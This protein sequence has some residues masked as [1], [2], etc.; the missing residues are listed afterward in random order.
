MKRPSDIPAAHTNGSP[1]GPELPYPVDR[2]DG[3]PIPQRDIAQVIW[4]HRWAMLLTF[5]LCV[6]GAVLYLVKA[7]PIYT[8]SSCLFV[9]QSGP[10]IIATSEGFMTQSKNYLFTQAELLKSTPIVSGALDNLDSRRLRT[11]DGTIDRVGFLKRRLNVSVGKK[12]DLI[13][14][15]LDSQYPQE[16]AE[17]VNAVV[18]S[19][20]AYHSRQKKDT[21]AEVLNILQREKA[22]RDAELRQRFEAAMNFKRANETISFGADNNNIV[23]QRLM[24]LSDALTS[25][26]LAM[27]DARAQYEATREM[28]S[29]PETI[30]YVAETQHL[31]SGPG[32]PYRGQEVLNGEIDKLRVEIASLRQEC[33]ENHPAVQAAEAKLMCLKEQRDKELERSARAYVA[34]LERKYIASKGSVAELRRSLDEQRKLAQQWNSQSIQYAILEG[35]LKRTERLCDLLDSRI[36]EIDIGED[37]G[38]LNISI[39]ETAQ[40]ARRPS[41]PNKA[42][43]MALSVGL[44]MLLGV[45]LALLRNWM[46]HRLRSVEEISRALGLPVLGIVPHVAGR[47][48]PAS[49]GKVVQFE[50]NSQVAESYR[51]IRTG[52]YFGAPEGETKTILITSP[53]QRDGKSTLASNLG[54]A[55]AQAGQRVLILDADCR[56]PSQ[57]ETF[58]IKDKALGLSGLLTGACSLDQAIRH[59]DVKG[60]DVLPCGAVPP[61]P[62]EML[63]SRAFSKLLDG[64]SLRYDYILLDAPPIMPVA[65]ARILGAISD[66]ALLVLR[67][68]K[69]SRKPSQEAVEAL[70]K[71][72][73]QILGVVV[74]DVPISKG[75]YGYYR[76]GYYG[77]GYGYGEKASQRRKARKKADRPAAAAS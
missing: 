25:A 26:E 15:A 3:S 71:V 8:S 11:F 74:N 64:L 46:D 1:S 22:K 35:D 48:G 52:L 44:G 55:M 27:M 21:A 50:P 68:D 23:I 67:A 29:D 2:Q 66:V 4:Q 6:A 7:T 33:T 58:Q 57:H 65:D 47:K 36:K 63:N 51:T 19:Y 9:E 32:N 41:K 17:I 73:S 42:E 49:L 70:L 54:L 16:A 60:L 43:V 38:A 72:G 77:Y 69:S 24:K 45:G 56:R 39:L 28:L 18:E 40:P 53:A 31:L 37:V 34:A 5:L 13:T 61:N 62:S 76:Y 20:I 14:V 12:D 10:R 30:R 75:R 59:S